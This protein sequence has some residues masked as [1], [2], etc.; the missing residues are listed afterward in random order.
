MGASLM[1]DAT[2]TDLRSGTVIFAAE[3]TITDTAH[4]ETA[5]AHLREQ[6]VGGLAAAR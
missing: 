4:P 6:L 5:L 3:P 1:L 2:I